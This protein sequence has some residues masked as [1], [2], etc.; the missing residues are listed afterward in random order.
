M[1][2]A[3][4]PSGER[5]PDD[6]GELSRDAAERTDVHDPLLARRSGIDL[7]PGV[8]YL[9]GNSLGPLHHAV[10]ERLHRVID[11]EWGGGLIG[12]WERLPDGQDG[13]RRLPQRVAAKLAPWVGADAD[14]L[15]VSDSTSVDL[16]KALAAARRLRPDRRVL[17][18]D[19]ANFPTDV[20][21]ARGL[22]E[23]T[24]GLEVRVVPSA[25]VADHLD[26]EVA[27]VTLTEV[28][29]RT[30]R[31]HD[32]A[33]LTRAAHEVGALAVWDLSHSAGA[34]AVDLH[35]WDADLAVGCTYKYLDGGPGAPAYTYV[36]R[37]W[38]EQAQT[39]LR[40]W[41][42]HAEP[43][44][45]SADYRPAAGADRFLDGTPPI[46]SLSALDAA[47]E[48]RDGL[49]PAE[50]EARAHRLTSR[51]I[52]LVDRDL[53]DA[54][55]VVSPRDPARRGAQVSLHHEHAGAVV[56]AL[57]ARGVIGDF[58]PD[59]APA[60]EGAGIVRFGFSPLVVSALD[61]HAAVDALGE[62]LAQRPWTASR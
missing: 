5:A 1:A 58:R 62:V 22:A 48:L 30:G 6:A 13:W 45:F 60:G 53:G 34:L 42:G 40:G 55:E 12:S 19:D 50:L 4:S 9:D 39:P 17:L 21:V 8:V 18:T 57:A 29:Y 37:R 59:P 32:A 23:L 47:L 7:P 33:A 46:L 25:E 56:A 35:G 61:V 38:H 51:F 20:Y 43:F 15:A 27:V 2:A 3:G 11:D 16:F 54:V 10:R 52:A 36:A 24:G 26:D 28:D 41:F 49:D 31:R 14:E 44:A